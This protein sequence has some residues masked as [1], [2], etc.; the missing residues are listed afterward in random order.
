MKKKKTIKKYQKG[1]H[2]REDLG[3]P[4]HNLPGQF[5]KEQF[6]SSK[7]SGSGR[8]GDV[9]A[10]RELGLRLHRGPGMKG[11]G[12]VKK[13]RASSGAATKGFGIEYK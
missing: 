8:Q 10:E 4:M 9:Q 12:G 1:G 5:K 13:K 2:A 7:D 6:I 3:T 11:G